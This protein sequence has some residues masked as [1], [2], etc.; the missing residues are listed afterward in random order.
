MQ[1]IGWWWRTWSFL[2]GGTMRFS[3]PSDICLLAPLQLDIVIIGWLRLCF[4]CM[5]VDC[6]AVKYSRK[7]NNETFIYIRTEYMV[8]LLVEIDS[9]W[10]HYNNVEPLRTINEYDRDLDW[11]QEI[12]LKSACD[13]NLCESIMVWGEIID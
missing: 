12:L 1:I 6:T 9:R 8:L 4:F 11:S 10:R 2:I 3:S 7:Q 5:V 13:M